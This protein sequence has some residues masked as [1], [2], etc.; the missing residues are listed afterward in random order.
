MNEI[1]SF[2]LK[3]RQI[4]QK[5]LKVDKEGVFVRGQKKQDLLECFLC[6]SATSMT[7]RL[8]TLK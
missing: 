4:R 6:H 1:D 7:G 5:S 3:E 8:L 2:W